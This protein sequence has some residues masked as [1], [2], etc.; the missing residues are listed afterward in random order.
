MP[1]KSTIKVLPEPIL[2]AVTRAI[3]EGRASIDEL[4][5]MVNGMGATVSRS[6]MARFKHNEEEKLAE[7]RQSQADAQIWAKEFREHPDSDL[8]R[9]LMELVKTVAFRS[10]KTALTTDVPADELSKLARAVRDILS[11]EQSQRRIEETISARV[12][13][14]AAAAAAGSAREAGLSEEAVERI[15]RDVL[16]V[17][18]PPA[19]GATA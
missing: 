5:A 2:E 6:A 13:K 7:Y 17:R 1:K 11:A 16:G 14:Q 9:T 10:Q 19:T 18:T 8:S 4:V 3:A 12:T 15:R